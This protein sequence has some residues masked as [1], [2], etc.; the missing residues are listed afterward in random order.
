MHPVHELKLDSDD[1]EPQPKLAVKQPKDTVPWL[2]YG[3][4]HYIVE[5]TYIRPLAFTHRG[6]NDVFW[7]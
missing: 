3:L 4:T 5:T 7:R 2:I 6:D 1:D